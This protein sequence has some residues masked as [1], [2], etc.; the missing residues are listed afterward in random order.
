MVTLILKILE[1]SQVKTWLIEEN[2][3]ES[4]ELFFIK[5]KLDMRRIADVNTIRVTV[6]RDFEKDGVKCRGNAAFMVEPSMT[7][8]E[9]SEKCKRAYAAA[10]FVPN[11]YYEIADPV[12]EECTI[13]DSDLAEISLEE[14]AGKVAAAIYEADCDEKS[15]VNSAEVFV[16]R[17]KVHILNSRGVDVSYIKYNT[18]GEFV[19]QCKE[20]LDVETHRSFSYDSLNTEALTGEVRE[21]LQLTRD[22]ALAS[23][24]PKAGTYDVILSGTY[25]ATIFEYYADRA[26]GSYIYQGYSDYKT[27]AFVQGKKEELEGQMLNL[28][29]IPT[30]PFSKEGTPMKELPC[31]EDGV[32]KNIHGGVRFAHYLNVPATGAYEKL[33]C[34]PGQMPFEEMKRKKGLY[35]VNFS[36][37]QMDA[38]SGYYGG[39]IRLAYLNDGEKITPV[40]GGSI[41]GT[42]YDA[43][44]NFV[45]SRE[46]QDISTFRGPKALLLKN[47]TV[48]GM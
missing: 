8:Q 33:A 13:M 7:E 45:F 11:P 48:A 1:E 18:N 5:K 15:Y 21:T 44:K 43:Q 29:Y 36:D 2:C 37:F 28:T 35:V 12:K 14:A 41:S 46:T 42:I 31:I 6:Y 30:Q 9:I 40:T 39:E 47:V 38:L 4:A 34:E 24:A 32:F 20:P 16:E 25:A 10:A 23:E 19:G 17:E 27:G 26:S 22:R 3:R